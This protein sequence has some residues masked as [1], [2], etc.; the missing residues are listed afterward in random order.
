MARILAV[1]LDDINAAITDDLPPVLTTLVE[2]CEFH[3][4][5]GTALNRAKLLRAQQGK[6][7]I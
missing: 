6:Q 4:R 2:L 5:E 7:G 3:W 1:L